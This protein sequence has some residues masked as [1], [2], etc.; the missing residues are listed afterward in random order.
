MMDSFS[1]GSVYYG[2]SLLLVL[3]AIALA[4]LAALI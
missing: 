4:V 2:R 1:E 3:G